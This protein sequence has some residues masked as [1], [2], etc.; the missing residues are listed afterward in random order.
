MVRPLRIGSKAEVIK[1]LRELLHVTGKRSSQ[2][3][4]RDCPWTQQL[5]SQVRP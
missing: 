4:R 1:T 2:A 5:L 3:K